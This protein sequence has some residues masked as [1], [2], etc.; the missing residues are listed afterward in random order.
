LNYV[1]SERALMVSPADLFSANQIV[2]LQPFSGAEVYRRFLDENRFVNRFYPN[3]RPR[4]LAGF[5]FS[6]PWIA[7]VM[8]LLLDWTIAPVYE[9][10]CRMLY[11]W[12]LRRRAHTWRSHDQVRLEREFLKLHTHSHRREVMEQFERALEQAAD[13]VTLEESSPVRV[14][15]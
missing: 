14:A 5:G 7:R 3:F 8:E 15:R 9:R 1:V 12:H 6:R 2:H 11:R 10:A 4:P 13:A